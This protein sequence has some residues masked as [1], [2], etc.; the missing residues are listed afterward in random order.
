MPDAANV[1]RKTAPQR[2]HD[3]RHQAWHDCRHQND[4]AKIEGWHTAPEAG[5]RH[6][7]HP[8]HVRLRDNLAIYLRPRRRHSSSFSTVCGIELACASTEIP[9]CCNTCAFDRFAVSV[10]KSASVICERA[11]L[12][13]VACVFVVEMA[14]W[15]VFCV[16]PSVAWKVLT[17]V[18]TLSIVLIAACAPDAD[19]TDRPLMPRLLASHFC[20]PKSAE[21]CWLSNAPIWKLIVPTP[22][23]TDWPLKVVCC[24]TR[25][26][27]VRRVVTSDCRFA[28]AFESSDPSPASTASWRIRCRLLTIDCSAPFVVCTIEMPLFAFAAPCSSALIDAVC[29]VEIAR[30]AASSA[31]VFT[32]LPDDRRLIACES[33]LCEPDRLFCAVSDMMLVLMFS[34]RFLVTQ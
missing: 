28:S 14:A 6:E 11:E 22:F 1:C 29:V 27:S 10:A 2:K 26:I 19:E 8:S 30:P 32:R 9:A 21:I 31:A 7:T 3:E 16:A 25:V 15:N 12:M 34:I 20:E 33:A 18:R 24:A 4:G 13:F 17:L 23:R 5:S